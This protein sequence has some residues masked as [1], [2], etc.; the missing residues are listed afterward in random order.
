[1]NTASMQQNHNKKSAQQLPVVSAAT[2]VLLAKTRCS[3]KRGLRIGPVY[4]SNQNASVHTFIYL[5]SSSPPWCQTSPN[6]TSQTVVL[7]L[8]LTCSASPKAPESLRG[9]Q[10]TESFDRY[11]CFYNNVE[12]GT[13]QTF[14]RTFISF[15]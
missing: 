4:V 8:K 11:L 3:D 9:S 5:P 7:I 15:R 10:L 13:V 12:S 6:L 2:T 1:M 14:G